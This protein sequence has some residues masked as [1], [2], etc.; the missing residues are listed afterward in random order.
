MDG[1]HLGDF[2]AGIDFYCCL[3][4]VGHENEDFAA[5][6]G[7]NDAPGGGNTAGGHGGAITDQQAEGSAA[8]RISGLDG[9]AGTDPDCCSGSKGRCF[10]GEHVIPQVFARMRDYGQAGG[11]F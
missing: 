3:A 5:V 8:G 6:P 11:C 1:D 7:V 10:E 4:Q 2:F 9:D